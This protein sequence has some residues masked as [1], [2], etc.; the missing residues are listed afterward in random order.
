MDFTTAKSLGYYFDRCIDLDFY[1][2]D[3]EHIASLR[4]PKRGLKP[5]ITIKGLF[6]EGGYA[7]DSYISIQN[8][9]FDID[10]WYPRLADIAF[11]SVLERTSGSWNEWN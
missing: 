10:V 11:E 8:M 7:I 3:M 2:T 9:A 4:T 6:I 1:N 5:T